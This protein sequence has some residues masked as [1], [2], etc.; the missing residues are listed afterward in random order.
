MKLTRTFLAS[1]RSIGRRAGNVKQVKT[2]KMADPKE[3]ANDAVT[4]EE[5]AGTAPTATAS[6]NDAKRKA[7]NACTCSSSYP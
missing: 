6:N 5:L 2:R 7:T 4:Q 1:K 3:G